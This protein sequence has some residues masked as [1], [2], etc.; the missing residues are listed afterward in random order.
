MR[1][2]FPLFRSAFLPSTHIPPLCTKPHLNPQLLRR[3]ISLNESTTNAHK[4][5]LIVIG[6]GSGGISASRQA[7]KL[8]ANVVLFEN[9]PLG[10]NIGGNLRECW[11]C[12]YFCNI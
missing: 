2:S 4:F 5:D 11:V 10:V 8:G 7:A 3:W 9:G 1:A 12:F 6:G